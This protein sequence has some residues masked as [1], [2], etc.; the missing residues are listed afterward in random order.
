MG[1][2]PT[3]VTLELTSS[4]KKR[5]STQDTPNEFYNPYVL[6]F[7]NTTQSKPTSG[8]YISDGE[9]GEEDTGGTM[10]LDGGDQEEDFG[11]SNYDGGNSE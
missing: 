10:E 9:D 3:N 4:A 1:S 11:M 2:P 6:P 7:P 8:I 5:K